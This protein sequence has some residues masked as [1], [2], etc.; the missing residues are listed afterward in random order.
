MFLN[1]TA[2]IKVFEGKVNNNSENLYQ[3]PNYLKKS[4]SHNFPKKKKRNP[5]LTHYPFFRLFPL[6]KFLKIIRIF[7]SRFWFFLKKINTQPGGALGSKYSQ[8]SLNG[9]RKCT[10]TIRHNSLRIT[11][12]AELILFVAAA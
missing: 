12:P 2:V 5:I 6:S 9:H 7:G 8:K 11:F 10:V 1:I 3:L 4:R